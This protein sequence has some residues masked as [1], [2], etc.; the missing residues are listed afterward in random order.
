MISIAQVAGWIEV[1]A[2]LAY[3]ESYD[4]CGLL[5]GDPSAEVK[6]CLL[7]LDV[8]EAVVAEAVARGCNMIIAHHPVIFSGLK[9]ITG[10]N[11][12]ERIVRDAIKN[13]IA[14][15]A[16]HTN[17]DNVQ[18][19]VN[20]VI[21]DKL[22][23]T[24]CR[25]LAP[26]KGNLKKLYTYVPQ[27]ELDVVKNALFAAGAGQIGEYSECSFTQQ[28]TGSFR[29]SAAANP[30]IGQA[31]GAR[32]NV[33]EAKLEVILPAYLEGKV[34]AAL[35]KA[36]PYEEVAYEI[37]TLDNTNQTIG[38][39]MIGELATPVT[40]LDFLHTVKQELKAGVVR[41]TPLLNRPVKKVAVCGGSGSFLVK[42]AI[43]AGAD[44][45]VTADMKYHQFF[46]AENQIVIAD[47]GHFESEQF[48][49]SLFYDHLTK[50]YDNFAVLLSDIQTNPVNYLS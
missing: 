37:I 30:A 23:L 15:Y 28:G 36:H 46:D 26:V 21:A 24:N 9:R 7:T 48:T 3:Q 33:I 44:V 11:Y 31:G 41:Y 45:F 6:G 14:I 10:R 38:A 12:V 17:L 16:C 50:K 27:P 18:H 35:R 5:V 19:G 49:V 2:P 34:L 29:P 40:E 13:D 22:G 4:N 20:K 43:G 8:T 47:V 25:I 39:G 32:E 1:L 42:Q